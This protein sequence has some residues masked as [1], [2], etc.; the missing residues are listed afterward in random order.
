VEGRILALTFGYGRNL[1]ALDAFERDFGLRVALNT[2]DPQ[3]LRSVDARTFEELTVMTR[4]QTSRASSLENFRIS[5]VEDILKAITG[6]PR[7]SAFG[8]RITG[9]DAA[10]VTYVPELMTLADKASSLLVA[11]ESD[12]YKERFGFIDELRGVRDPGKINKLNDTILEVLNGDELGS[13]HL[14]PPDIVDL[15]EI[16]GFIYDGMSSDTFVDLDVER[17]RELASGR[18]LTIELLRKSKIGVTYRGAGVPHLRWSAYD[19][20]VAEV[21]EAD[22]L[23]VLSAGTWYEVASDFAARVANDVAERLGDPNLL[24]PASEV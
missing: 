23:F 21:R 7:D 9:A 13:L 5:P 20:L 2:I 19:C 18:L 14:A 3:T 12:F 11:Y 1:L 6:T 4:S 8:S 24:P 15:Q 16:D 10:K 17:Y 22:R